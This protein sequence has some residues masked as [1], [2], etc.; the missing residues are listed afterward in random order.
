MYMMYTQK[1]VWQGVLLYIP[2]HVVLYWQNVLYSA[3]G[4]HVYLYML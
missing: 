4:I 1:D 2:V 3:V